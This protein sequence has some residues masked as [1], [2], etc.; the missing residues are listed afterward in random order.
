MVARNN[1]TRGHA[2]ATLLAYSGCGLPRLRA[3]L[4]SLMLVMGSDVPDRLRIPALMWIEGIAPVSGRSDP[5]A[6]A[7]TLVGRRVVLLCRDPREAVIE[8]YRRYRVE[9]RAI[10]SSLDDLLC[11]RP[12]GAGPLTAETRYGLRGCVD[13]MSTIVRCQH[14]FD[15]LLVIHE[16]DLD[17]D[18]WGTVRRVAEFVGLS[19]TPRDLA[20]AGRRAGPLARSFVL[21]D[22]ASPS[23][24]R[25]DVI[26]APRR[27]RCVPMT[28]S[29]GQR[30]FADDMI[31]E[32]LHPLLDRY[33]RAAPRQP[34]PRA[35]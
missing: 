3:L 7:S 12:A 8:N 4:D 29:D 27:E 32:H 21:S 14:T 15:A 2:A 22:I 28:L 35:A 10:G 20:A 33:K 30:V 18:P 24:G 9:R 16:M 34:A 31:A 1:D 13:F 11:A 19:P 17:A 26:A 5:A 23:P 6:V 25:A